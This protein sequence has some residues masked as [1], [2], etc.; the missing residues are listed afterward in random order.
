MPTTEINREGL[1][2]AVSAIPPGSPVF[3]INLLRFRDQADYGGH[4]DLAPCTGREAYFARYLPAF[5]E[6]ASPYGTTELVFGGNVI[7][8]VVGPLD[9]EW[10]GIGLVRY[11]G[12]EVFLELTA[13]SAYLAKAEPHRAAALADWRLYATTSLS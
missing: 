12:I 13:D 5:N 11:P 3:M 10:D 4:T 7:G 1:D 8:T 6:T 2:A 9:E